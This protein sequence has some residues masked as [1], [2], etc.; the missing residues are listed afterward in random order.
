MRLAGRR[1][2]RGKQ[3]L[4]H[5]LTI[6]EEDGLVL[7]LHVDMARLVLASLQGRLAAALRGQGNA[8]GLDC[9]AEARGL[10]PETQAQ[11]RNAAHEVV[12]SGISEGQAGIIYQGRRAGWADKRDGA[13]SKVCA[14]RV[15]VHGGE[16]IVEIIELAGQSSPSPLS[17][18]GRT[19]R[20]TPS[21]AG[22]DRLN[23][24]RSRSLPPARQSFPRQIVAA[25]TAVCSYNSFRRPHHP[26]HNVLTVSL[27]A[28]TPDACH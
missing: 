24:L 4:V 17:W 12:V 2:L 13:L 8:S 14:Q 11:P 19:E 15:T 23:P 1:V 21:R 5:L 25:S 7:G 28:A 10:Q 6:K 18:F 27:S 22:A 3:R 16:K 26:V 9:S 20:H